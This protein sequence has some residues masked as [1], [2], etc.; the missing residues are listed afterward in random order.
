MYCISSLI[1]DYI[2]YCNILYVP[3][4]KSWII[5]KYQDKEAIEIGKRYVGIGDGAVGLTQ[6]QEVTKDKKMTQFLY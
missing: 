1:K 4:K 2:L 3:Y 5:L 6:V